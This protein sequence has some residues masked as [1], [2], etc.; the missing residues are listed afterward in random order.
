MLTKYDKA[1]AGGIAAIV[2]ALLFEFTTLDNDVVYAIGTLLTA[3][4]VYLV[5]NKGA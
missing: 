4:A 2:T 3:A 5:P 1:G